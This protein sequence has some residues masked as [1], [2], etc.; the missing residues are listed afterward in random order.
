MAIS[1]EIKPESWT[2]PNIEM[3]QLLKYV[4]MY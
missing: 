1:L 4:G 2:T 3:N